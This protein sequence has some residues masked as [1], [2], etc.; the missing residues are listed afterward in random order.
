MPE[1]EEALPVDGAATLKIDP[2]TSA[3]LLVD[4]QVDFMPGGALPVIEGESI[5]PPVRALLDRGL[6]SV[7]V[8]TQDWHPPEHI[9]FA[10]A[11]RGRRPFETIELY[12]QPQTL[13]PDHCVQNSAGA[14]LHSAVPRG[15]LSAIVR[16]GSDRLVD[17]YSAFRNNWD[18]KGRR[19][20]TG[21]AGLLRERGVQELVVA[22]L[23][24]DY[25]VLWSAQDAAES[26][27]RTTV[28]WDLTRPV[29]PSSDDRVRAALTGRGVRIMTTA[30]LHR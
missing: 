14:E 26:G 11:H 8:A 13:W 18:P 16:K 20:P 27:F 15:P 30:Q 24:R 4:L 6:F 7:V 1:H 10:S 2:S 28:L 21:L 12:G 19:P 5:L 23:A 22:G 9:S 25:C 29:D 3:L 17:S